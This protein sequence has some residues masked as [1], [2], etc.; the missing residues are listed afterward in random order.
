MM[1]ALHRAATVLPTGVLTDLQ[2]NGSA[3]ATGRSQQP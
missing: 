2:D 3:F 1:S